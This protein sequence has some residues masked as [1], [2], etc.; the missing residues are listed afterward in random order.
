MRSTV[1]N[2]KQKQL[3]AGAKALF[4]V[5]MV[6]AALALTVWFSEAV[7]KAGVLTGSLFGALTTSFTSRWRD[8]RFW[9]VVALL[10]SVH[11]VAI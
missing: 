4:G 7:V 1:G 8:S 9:I 3:G 2:Q 11:L 6:L 5:S 10:F